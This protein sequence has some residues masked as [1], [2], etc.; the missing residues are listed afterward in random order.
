MG[1]GVRAP[2]FLDLY[3][4][5]LEGVSGSCPSALHPGKYFAVPIG[6]GVGWAP[7]LV[8]VLGGPQNW[9]GCWV[10]PRTGPGVGLAPELVRVLGWPQNWSGCWVGPRTAP[11]AVEGRKISKSNFWFLHAVRIRS[12]L[13]RLRCGIQNTECLFCHF[14]PVFRC[15]CWRSS[16]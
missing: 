3:Y 6:P 5:E 11:V 7:E 9:S 8:R 15:A 13:L 4:M 12:E 2:R 10:D 16:E 14:C 1:S